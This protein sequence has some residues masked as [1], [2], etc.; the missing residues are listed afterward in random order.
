MVLISVDFKI[1]NLL[2]MFH[3]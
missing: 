3:I 1:T 2:Y